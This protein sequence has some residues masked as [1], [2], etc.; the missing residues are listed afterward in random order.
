MSG[1]V[2]SNRGAEVTKAREKGDR[3]LREGESDGKQ[4]EC[5]ESKLPNP[6]LY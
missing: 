4:D 3:G 2:S 1:S 5:V 6:C